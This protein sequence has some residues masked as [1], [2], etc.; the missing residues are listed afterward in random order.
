MRLGRTSGG[1]IFTPQ[2][3]SPADTPG[4]PRFD[5]WLIAGL[6]IVALLMVVVAGVSLRNTRQLRSDTALVAH[7]NEVLGALDGLLSTMKD[8]ETGERGF[9][10]TGDERYLEP[11]RHA[12]GVVEERLATVE[13]LTAGD[14]RQAAR[15]PR[16]RVLVRE[17]LD[18][19]ARTIALLKK[20][21]L[22]AA[23]NEVLTH[24]G[25]SRMD[26]IRAFIAAMETDERALLRERRDASERGY[27]TSLLSVVA[28]A[29]LGLAALAGFVGILRGHLG[30]RQ[31]AAAALHEQREWFRTTLTSIGDAVIA[32][33]TQARVTFLNSVAA[34]LTGWTEDEARGLP[35]ETVFRIVNEKTGEPAGNPVL[36]ALEKG[37]VVGLANHTILISKTGQEWPID[38][39]AAPIRDQIG[40]VAGVVLVFRDI[41]ARKREEEDRRTRV[42]RLADAEERTRSI[43]DNVVDGI[44]TIDDRGR[45]QTFNRAAERLFGYPAKETIGQNVNMLMPAPYHAEHDGYVAS[46]VRTRQPRIIGIGREVE[47][48]RKDGSTFPMELA[49]SEF[50]LGERLFFTGIVRDI[51][52]RK[53]SEKQMYGLLIELKEADR[54]KDEFLALLAHELRSPLAPL[55][56]ALEIA[57]R[58]GGGDEVLLR[59]RAT[60]DRQ[61]TQVTRLV[62]DLL[63][64][65]RITRDRLELRR[66]NVELARVV[67]DAVELCRPAME[68]RRQ[69]VV[70]TLPADPIHLFADPVRLAQVLGN[71]LS[72]A[73]KYSEPGSPIRLTAAR[74]GNDV[75]IAV[76]DEGIGISPDALTDVFDMFMQAPGTRERSQGGLGIGLT[77]VKRLVELHEGKVEAHS[78]GAGLGSEFVVR[79]PLP[80]DTSLPDQAAVASF[81]RPALP[82]RILVVDDDEDSAE[83]LATLLEVTGNETVSAHDGLEAV[84]AAERFRPEVVLLDIGL[85]VLNGYEA[86]RRIRRQP[87]G[88]H[89]VLVA[90]T[91]WGQDGDRRKSKEAGFDE[92]MVKPLDY[93]A[94][95]NLL[96][97][98]PRDP[99]GSLRRE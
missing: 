21:G 71:V 55:R 49:V 23:Q 67:N 81:D 25:T 30:A 17:K 95:V 69:E 92:H 77:L 22:E 72:N 99:P 18:E 78:D 45:I 91:G 5:K 42:D 56:N 83:S 86:A 96:A 1:R 8:A 64:V 60:M 15:I 38:D 53:R 7:T 89:M 62:D 88:K 90:L 47:G 34:T 40:R 44:I 70:V 39:S 11:Y 65:S 24:L 46:Y 6:G 3:P 52:E 10:I 76:K 84:E 16:L 66:E 28:T 74:E 98:L 57:K 68:S 14:P 4:S 43:V 41:S 20:A 19:L 50:R 31:R 80:T 97:T 82:H 75:V 87:W 37:Q 94:L 61:L 12:I 73:S 29:L 51:T 13:R 48:R 63:D 35:L 2:S 9:L 93:D 33:D 59:A 27:K 79:L 85:P 54:R 26:A 58:T 36:R 32:T